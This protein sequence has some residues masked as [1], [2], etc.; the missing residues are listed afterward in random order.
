[1]KTK[2]PFLT[3]A[4][5]QAL[6]INRL[7]RLAPAGVRD[8]YREIFGS[9]VPSG[10]C[11]HA[12]RKIAWHVQ[13]EREGGLPDAALQHAFVIARS[14]SLRV[15]LA[16]KSARLRRHLSPDHTLTVRIEPDYDSRLPMP[17][18]VIVKKH[19]SRNIIVRVLDNGFEFDGRRFSSL[20]AVA[21]DITG[22]KWNGFVFFGLAKESPRAGRK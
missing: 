20:S 13:A 19:K 18:S 21:H 11:E 5:H 7:A 15:R 3:T 4:E 22:T 16:S 8:L 14:A 6:D 17:G 12:R 10:N 2:R 9:G 1:M